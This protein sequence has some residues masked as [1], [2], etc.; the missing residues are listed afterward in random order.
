MSEAHPVIAVSMFYNEVDIAP[1]VVPHMLEEVDRVII[2][3]NRS[4]DGTYEALC[5]LSRDDSRLTVV[6]EGGFGYRQAE[7]MNRL[8]A[9]VPEAAW[10]MGW[11]ADEWWDSPDGRIADV[12]MALPPNVYLTGVPVTDM[13][14]QPDDPPGRNPFQ[15]IQM[16]RPGSFYSRT[17]YRKCAFR[18]APDRVLLQG[19][20]GLD[21]IPFPEPGPLRIRHYPY[22]TL[23]QATMKLRHGRSAALASG[24]GAGYGSHWQE[25]GSYDDQDM[26]A[27]WRRWTDP[28]GLE[29]WTD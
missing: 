8:V 12:L 5:R 3:D 7:V 15:R 24:L 2:A 10:A 22:R 28:R 4:T 23:R 18:P 1:Y 13:V 21:R 17:E 20:H 9:T 6:V 26:A 29:L 11:D 19:N 25:W 27:W 16:Y 14:P